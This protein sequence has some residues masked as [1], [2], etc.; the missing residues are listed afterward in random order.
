MF[1]VL[2]LVYMEQ[3]LTCN[4]LQ[5]LYGPT[6]AFR[7]PLKHQADVSSNDRCLHSYFMYARSGGFDEFAHVSFNCLTIGTNIM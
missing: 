5:A 3:K 7:K 1:N 4:V 6:Y 2:E